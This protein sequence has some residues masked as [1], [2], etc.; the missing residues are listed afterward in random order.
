VPAALAQ[1]TGPELMLEKEGL[2]V[3]NDR[4]LNAE[5]PAHLLDD[6]ITP[7]SRLFVRNNGLVPQSALDRDANGWTLV[8]DGEV[9]NEL[10]LTIDE[11]KSGFENVTLA[12]VLECGG[13]GRAFFNPGS[14]GNQWTVGAVGCPQWTGVRL[15]DVLE[16][17]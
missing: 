13:N 6:D 2:T 8:I 1:D 5:T 4:P 17:A 9:E 16:K 11:L 7:Y 14:S 15:R 10:S 3:H 12:L